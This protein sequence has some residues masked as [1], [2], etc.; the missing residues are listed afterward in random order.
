MKWA[1]VTLFGARATHS[2]ILGLCPH[3]CIGLV[4]AEEQKK[5]VEK[6]AVEKKVVEKKVVEKKVVERKEAAAV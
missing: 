4:I 1:N 5:A 3:C 6:K 2:P